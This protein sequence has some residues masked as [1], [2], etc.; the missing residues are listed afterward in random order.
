MLARQKPGG[1]S[2]CWWLDNP[3]RVAYSHGCRVQGRF[4]NRVPPPSRE[5]CQPRSI[6]C[7]RS[8]AL[9]DQAFRPFSKKVT[10]SYSRNPCSVHWHDQGGSAIQ[11][12]GSVAREEAACR[13]REH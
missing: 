12:R 2:L 3:A 7:H 4:C 13:C 6:C 5:E 8:P 1:T 11:N 9:K 10:G